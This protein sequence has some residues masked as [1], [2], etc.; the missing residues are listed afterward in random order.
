[1]KASQLVQ[2]IRIKANLSSYDFSERIGLSRSAA[3]QWE[4]ERA[5][6]SKESADVICSMFAEVAPDECE[7]L[8]VLFTSAN[9][10]IV[11]RRPRGK[12]G[13]NAEPTTKVESN[14]ER[15]TNTKPLCCISVGV[16]DVGIYDYALSADGCGHVLAAFIDP[17]DDIC[18]FKWARVKIAGDRK[19][20]T[21]AGLRFYFDEAE[22]CNSEL[23]DTMC[24]VER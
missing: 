9:V 24:R 23:N 5:S 8:S 14:R 3:Y 17:P 22:Y 12:R 19:Y 11:K 2:I 20:I 13:V 18:W 16:N 6:L 4:T 10:K 21:K 7:E 15:Y 1:M